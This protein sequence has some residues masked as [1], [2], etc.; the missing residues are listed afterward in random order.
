MLDLLD[1]YLARERESDF[2]WGEG[3]GDCIL[4]LIGWGKLIKGVDFG[5]SWRGLYHSKEEA[6]ALLERRGGLIAHMVEYLGAPRMGSPAVRGDVGI[7]QTRDWTF[8]MIFD[9]H[10]WAMRDHPKGVRHLRIGVD[11]VWSMG[12]GG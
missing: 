11:C 6:R 1:D 10:S 12:F 5:V 2:V 4:F 8:G 9:G 3:N 7:L